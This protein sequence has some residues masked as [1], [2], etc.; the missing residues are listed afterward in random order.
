MPATLLVDPHLP[1]IFHAFTTISA[2]V[3]AAKAG[4]TIKVAPGTYNGDIDVT[5]PLTIL[6]GQV[7]QTLFD[8]IGPSIIDGATTSTGFAFGANNITVKNFTIQKMQTGVITNHFTG[9]NIIN[10][11]FQD[12]GIGVDLTT[13]LASNVPT[14]TV[15][16]NKFINDGAGPTPLD[17]ILSTGARNVV[18]KNNRFQTPN[19]EAAIHVN[20]ANQ[21]KNVQILDNFF[22]G[23][24]QVLVANVTKA[25][26]DGNTILT[27][28]RSNLFPAAIHLGGNVTSSEV[29]NNTLINVHAASLFEG[30]ILDDTD[31]FSATNT[32]NKISGN[33]IQGFRVGVLVNLATKNTVSNNTVTGSVDDGL[34]VAG[35]FALNNTISSNNFIQNHGSGIEVISTSATSANVIAKNTVTAN[36]NDGILL[37]HAAGTTLTGNVVTENAN[38][39]IALDTATGNT[40]S[41]NT[42]NFNGVTA[43]LSGFRLLNSN[44]NTLS[45]TS[46]STTATLDSTL[47]TRRRTR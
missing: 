4:D 26:I 13:S 2:A 18:I 1:P 34:S 30:V 12:D 7:T 43:G 41:S 32:S 21:S 17:D 14:S 39:G 20:G 37:D 25:K 44:Q 33:S 5:K 9:F 3:D 8:G 47:F 10:N 45:K 35:I 28:S 24:S 15:S 11:I 42:A 23:D 38:F 29:A 22:S 6:G 19:T 40:M 36:S 16:G 31:I 46:P 27:P